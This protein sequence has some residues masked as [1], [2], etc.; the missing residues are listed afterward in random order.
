[1]RGH[2]GQAQRAPVLR[3]DRDVA[4]PVP[5]EPQHGGAEDPAVSQVVP[6][7]RLDR[8]E[9]LA[10]DERAGP[11]RLQRQDPDH[12]LVV[13]PH[14]GA[15]R[16]A[17]ARRAPTTAGTAR[18]RGRPAAR[19]RAAA[20]CA[21]CRGTAGSPPR[22]ARSG[23]HGGCDQSWP[24]WLNMSGGRAHRDA[25][26]EHV[27]QR[28]RV[29]TLAGARRRRGR[30]RS[31]IAMPAARAARWAAAS[32]S[33]SSHCSQQWKSTRSAS[34]RRTSAAAGAVRV[35]Q[36]GWPGRASPRRAPRRARTR[37]RSRRSPWPSRSQERAGRPPARPGERGTWCTSS[38]ASRLAVQAA[39]RS[40]SAGGGVGR[41]HRSRQLVGG[42]P[43]GGLEVAE[44][45]H[46]LDPQ[47]QRVGEPPGDR[48]V[49]RGLH[50]RD[51]RGR[52]QRVD[53]DEVRAELVAAPGGQV[54]EVGEV[55]DPP[56][57]GRPQ[58]CTAGQRT[59]RPRRS[60]RAGGSS[61]PRG[62]TTSGVDWPAAR[63]TAACRGASPGAGR[64]GAR[65]SPHRPAVPSTTAGGTQWSC[66]TTSVRTAPSS[67]S[68]HTAHVRAVRRRAPR[69]TGR[70]PDR[71]TRQGGS[72]R[73]HS[74]GPVLGQRGR[75]PLRGGAVDAQ[76][77]QHR[78][79]SWV[80]RPRPAGPA[81]P[82]TRWPR[83][84][85]LRARAVP[86]R[87]PPARSPAGRGA[88]APRAGRLQLRGQ[89]DQRRLVTLPA[90]QLDAD[91]AGRPRSSA[92]AA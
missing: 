15:R 32:C 49:R 21:A 82:S 2:G 76:P 57:P 14:V 88:L 5:L 91:R 37:W 54:G 66:W 81:S 6:H 16:T 8:A 75:G 50:R 84:A 83:R 31:R 74:A 33:S 35:V 78:D 47:V 44:L 62:V 34:R 42:G 26:G 85:R 7:P 23:R 3:S 53:Q 40:S 48:Q 68:T 43:V 18:A 25:L 51:R 60:R 17:A 38:R 12:R 67:S 63:R 11:V 30:A 72:I 46:G 41:P 59:P 27:P 64:T 10:D 90:D 22:P 86:G 73:R 45:G 61:S 71:T 58:R 19:R 24:C 92:G 79:E 13:V 55:A 65:T 70:S 77:G 29:R 69:T 56:R 80:G 1:M 20:R 28:P 52:V 4:V 9:V 87:R 89:R 36:L 39:S